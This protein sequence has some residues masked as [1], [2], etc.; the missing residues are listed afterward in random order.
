MVTWT[1]EL[2]FAGLQVEVI[3]HHALWERSLDEKERRVL[4]DGVEVIEVTT[5]HYRDLEGSEANL[6]RLQ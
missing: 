1:P 2:V 3:R 5:V 4:L 6:R